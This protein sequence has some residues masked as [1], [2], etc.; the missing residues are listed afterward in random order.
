[1]TRQPVDPASVQDDDR[2]RRFIR[3][4]KSVTIL[5]YGDSGYRKVCRTA[6]RLGA[7]AQMKRLSLS[8]WTRPC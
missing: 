6:H 1:M 4:G 8:A 3:E 7:F 2:Y 5:E